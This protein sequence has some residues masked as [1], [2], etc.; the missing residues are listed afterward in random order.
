LLRELLGPLHGQLTKSPAS[1]I[2]P[3]EHAANSGYYDQAVACRNRLLH[4]SCVSHSDS[5]FKD[6]HMLRFGLPLQVIAGRQ[7]RI[8]I[9]ARKTQ[10]V[11][12]RIFLYNTN[13]YLVRS[14]IASPSKNDENTR[15]ALTPAAAYCT[16]AG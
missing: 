1:A 6:E 5:I 12:R 14:Q 3:G 7:G 9:A 10:A 15:S 16:R 8:A 11:L 4:Q 13:F 2:R